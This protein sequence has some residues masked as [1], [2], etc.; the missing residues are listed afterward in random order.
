MG[1]AG[2]CVG[3]GK[4]FCGCQMGSDGLLIQRARAYRQTAADPGYHATSVDLGVDPPSLQGGKVQVALLVGAAL[5]A[6][7]YL[8]LPRMQ[9]GYDQ[10]PSGKKKLWQATLVA[11]AVGMGLVLVFYK[12]GE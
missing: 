9:R 2:A 8:I 10:S 6:I 3:E 1:V 11:A 7:A 4:F 5:A 12:G